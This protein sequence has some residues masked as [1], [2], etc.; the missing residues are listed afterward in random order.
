[1]KEFLTAAKDSIGNVDEEEAV[2]F[3]HDGREVKFYKPSPGQAAIMMTMGGREM[4]A[5]SAG[6]FIQLF[7]ELMDD[8]TRRYFTGRLLDRKDAFS[9]LNSEGGMF[10]IW[11]ALT[12]DWSARPTK[13]PS[14]YQPPRRS[15]GKTST[16]S[17]RAKGSTSSRSRSTDSSR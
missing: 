17:S 3:L 1:V 5:Q 16:A 11:E 9:N 13:Q 15:G 2:T 8:D 4:D 6:L 10:D 14:D 12:E 7:L